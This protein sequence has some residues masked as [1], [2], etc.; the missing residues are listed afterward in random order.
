MLTSLEPLPDISAGD[1]LAMSPLDGLAIGAAVACVASNAS[2]SPG[3]GEELQMVCMS[4]QDAAIIGRLNAVQK[5]FSDEKLHVRVAFRTRLPVLGLVLELA[6]DASSY[7]EDF[8]FSSANQP[9]DG[10]AAC[11]EVSGVKFGAPER[12]LDLYDFEDYEV[13]VC[14]PDAGMMAELTVGVTQD[15]ACL[16]LVAGL[17]T[18]WFF[19]HCWFRNETFPEPRIITI[20]IDM[21]NSAGFDLTLDVDGSAARVYDDTTGEYISSGFLQK[22]VTLPARSTVRIEYFADLREFLRRYSDGG[23]VGLTGQTVDK[24]LSSP[25]SLD[26]VSRA[27]ILGTTYD[28]EFSLHHTSLLG[29]ASL[30]G[31]RCEVGPDPTRCRTNASSY[32]AKTAAT[33]GSGR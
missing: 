8:D 23:I 6:Q 27:T 21:Y 1:M 25:V 30:S 15:L 16:D 10:L 32:A 19:A 4:R 13:S 26:I 29:L 33:F 2:Y 31:C 17:N 9:E 24:V 11:S 14:A 28:Q 20:P 5:G 18:N 7:A 22:T 3:W 12:V